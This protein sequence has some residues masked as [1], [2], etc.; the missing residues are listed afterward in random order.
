VIRE[1]CQG[2]FDAPLWKKKIEES[3][4]ASGSSSGLTPNC[5]YLYGPGVL[6]FALLF[7]SLG[8]SFDSALCRYRLFRTSRLV[9]QT[10][11]SIA[12]A[13]RV[14]FDLEIICSTIFDSSLRNWEWHKGKKDRHPHLNLILLLPK[15]VDA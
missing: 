2:F 3:I 5:A 15:P 6:Y 4:R 12:L 10:A 1:F 11:G 13:L 14:Y 8:T 9:V 7:S